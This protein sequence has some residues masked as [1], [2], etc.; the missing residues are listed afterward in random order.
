VQIPRSKAA[1][2][3][4]ERVVHPFPGPPSDAALVA[5]LRAGRPEAAGQL[6]ERYG[7]YVERLVV[8]VLGIDTEVPD[9]INEVFAR[10]FERIG[11][12]EDPN[13][14]KAWL[15]SI[16]LFTAKSFLRDRRS[17]RRFLGFFAPEE[18]PEVAVTGAT[19]EVT[20]A[21]YRTYQVLE[22]FP[23]EERIAF[24]LRFIDGMGLSEVAAM[25][26]LSLGTIKR[27]LTRAQERFVTAA[28]RDP[29]L[30]E[31]VQRG[32]RWGKP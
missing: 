1:E 25:M 15:G 2:P 11:Q 28:E 9:L 3:N 17:R 7:N 6:L 21:L 27:R 10:A 31:R 5:A 14:L 26:G 23:P 19:A 30:R 13:A 20:L 32:Q 24:A 4:D 8:R 29:V 16:A 18:L 12:L 22:T